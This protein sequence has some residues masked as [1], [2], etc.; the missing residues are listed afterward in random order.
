[1]DNSLLLKKIYKTILTEMWPFSTTLHRI[2]SMRM[3]EISWIFR[4][5]RLAASTSCP[6]RSPDFSPFDFILWGFLKDHAYQPPLPTHLQELKDK[7][8]EV[9][10]TFTLD[11]AQTKQKKK[12]KTVANNNPL[13]GNTY[14]T[15]G[16]SRE[17]GRLPSFMTPLYVIFDDN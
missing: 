9:T 8:A 4:W 16:Q 2:T 17:V 1:M 5:K 12:P 15:E 11:T 10:A 7:I 14:M 13:I 3:C 6:P